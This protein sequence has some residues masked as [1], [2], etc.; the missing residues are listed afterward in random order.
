M[1]RWLLLGLSSA[2]AEEI[3]QVPWQGGR[4]E[5][6]L[7]LPLEVIFMGIH[8]YHHHHIYIYYIIDNVY[9]YMYVCGNRS[10]GPYKEF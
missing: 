4:G 1:W 5:V 9:I 7:G 3:T 10:K 2:V 8:T 6:E